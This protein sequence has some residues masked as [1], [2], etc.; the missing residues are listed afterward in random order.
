MKMTN[1]WKIV[2]AGRQIRIVNNV[3]NETKLYINGKRSE[4]EESQFGNRTNYIAKLGQLGAL[5]ISKVNTKLGHELRMYHKHNNG[6]QL[7]LR[8]EL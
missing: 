8:S 1:T 6:K 5:I 7:L 3:A 4:L 2:L